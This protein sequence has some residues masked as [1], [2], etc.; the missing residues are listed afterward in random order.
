MKKIL[1]LAIA[2]M[3]MAGCMSSV[4][5]EVIPDKKAESSSTSASQQKTEDVKIMLACLRSAVMIYYSESEGL[6]PKNLDILVGKYLEKIPADPFA[7]SN[8][9]VN[10]FDG[11]GGWYYVTDEKSVNVGCVFLNLDGK[12]EKGVE[13]KSY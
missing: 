12:D 10:T 8:K 9:V 2:G 6:W 1:W 13:Y 11:K 7:G 4:K 3:V 5:T